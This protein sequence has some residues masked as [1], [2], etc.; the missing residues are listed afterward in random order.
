MHTCSLYLSVRPYIHP[1]IHSVR[2]FCVMSIHMS[3]SLLI[4]STVYYPFQLSIHPFVSPF[5]HY[6]V[7]QQLSISFCT[8]ALHH[9]MLHTFSRFAQYLFMLHANCLSFAGY[10]IFYVKIII[11]ILNVM[12]GSGF[13]TSR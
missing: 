3:F 2:S 13:V 6:L 11:L 4:C 7:I 12:S 5:I 9:L 10:F 1:C 8:F